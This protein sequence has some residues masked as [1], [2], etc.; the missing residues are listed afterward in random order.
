MRKYLIR[1]KCFDTNRRWSQTMFGYSY[2]IKNKF[3][4]HNPNTMIL[5]I[6][7]V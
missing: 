1:Y 7:E 6:T 4:R 2:E 3:Y 5:S